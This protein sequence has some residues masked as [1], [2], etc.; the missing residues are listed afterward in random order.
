MTEDP[1]DI[2]AEGVLA[3]DFEWGRERL[4]QLLQ[5]FC[6]SSLTADDALLEID[7]LEAAR[8]QLAPPQ[9]SRLG[10]GSYELNTPS[11]LLTVQRAFGW[12]VRRD[13]APLVWGHNRK[14][15]FFDKLEDAKKSALLHQSDRGVNHFPDGTR[16]DDST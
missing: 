12:I 5:D 15:T 9:W 4:D 13:A 11:G 14:P 3:D 1:D 7:R 8:W 10:V 16:W 2:P 6:G